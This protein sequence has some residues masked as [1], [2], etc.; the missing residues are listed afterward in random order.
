MGYCCLGVACELYRRETGRGEWDEVNNFCLGEHTKFFIL[1]PPVKK[2]LGLASLDACFDNG[3]EGLTAM[4]D[5]GIPF[6]EIADKIES[7]PEG[8]FA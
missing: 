6:P 8:L 1:P 2:W 7:E 3:P 5:L 4:N